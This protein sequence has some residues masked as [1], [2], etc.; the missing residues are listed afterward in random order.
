MSAG[1]Y[2]AL[3]WRLDPDGVLT[4][5][6]NRPDR[7]NALDTSAMNELTHVFTR[8]DRD[9]AVRVVIVTGAGRAF[10]A[11]GD[12][13]AG[14]GTFDAVARG[15]ADSAADHVE[16]GGPLAMSVFTNR[17]PF[18]AAI[19][20]PAVGIGL[21]MTLPMDLRIAVP[22]AKLALPFTRRG[23]VPDACAS[24]FLPRL[25]GLSAALDWAGTG[26]TFRA[27]EAVRAGL[28]AELVAPER[29]LA[30]A[31]E[32]AEEYLRAA[33]VAVAVTRQMV[34]RMA[35]AEHPLDAYAVEAPA[36]FELGRSA[37]AREG[38]AAFL[39]KRE[40]KFPLRVSSDLPAG[41]PWWSRAEAL[42]DPGP[43]EPFGDPSP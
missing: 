6:I 1:G 26:R 43:I 40:P 15:R 29:L 23:I 22:G 21:T 34:L 11:G 39:A 41:Y 20:G 7:L 38:V 27:E 10:C 37:D 36:I 24:W 9:D 13:S 32:R 35:S 12:L 4:V 16:T 14:P 28:V 30:R 31:R 17:K 3:G 8:A 18:I 33:P 19:N 5:T 2:A 42:A 25:V